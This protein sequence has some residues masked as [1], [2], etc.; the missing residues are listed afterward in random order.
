[1]PR[2]F[3]L[4]EL[5]IAVSIIGLLGFIA[6]PS[7]NRFS[8]DQTLSNTTKELTTKLREVQSSSRSKIICP[9]SKASSIWYVRFTSAS[10][11][12]VTVDCQDSSASTY[13]A[14]NL[15][16]S[17]NLS[18]CSNNFSD[19][20]ISWDNASGR[21]KFKCGGSPYNNS[22]LTIT[23]TSDKTSTTKVITVTNA[24]IINLN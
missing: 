11:Y 18:V 20:N 14:I 7:I 24:G 1:M 9:S 6:V 2:G 3:S 19:S 13:P 5:L 17:I 4:I 10:S 21:V 15:P 8:A 16:P 23:L 12:Q 22:I